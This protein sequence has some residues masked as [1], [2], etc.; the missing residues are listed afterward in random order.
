MELTRFCDDPEDVEEGEDPSAWHAEWALRDDS[1]ATEDSGID[2]SELIDGVVQD[3]AAQWGS[4]YDLTI[5]WKL[6]AA[7]PLP[8]GQTIEGILS[9]LGVTLPRTVPAPPRLHTT[10]AAPGAL[11]AQHTTDSVMLTALR[12]GRMV[13]YDEYQRYREGAALLLRPRR[14]GGCGTGPAH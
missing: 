3:A 4:R 11:Q 5:E 9:D 8:E 10:V 7:D 12:C 1:V 13:R 14:A 6:N 2:V